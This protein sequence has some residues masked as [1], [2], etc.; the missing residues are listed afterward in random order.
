MSAGRAAELAEKV[1]T[2][3]SWES[4]TP[5]PES[6]GGERAEARDALA[7]LVSLA[8]TGSRPLE[9]ALRE[10]DDLCCGLGFIRRGWEPAYRKRLDAIVSVARAALASRDDSGEA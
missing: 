3:L 2:V 4:P 6:W 8:E 5:E 7:E 9:E 1:L 10:I